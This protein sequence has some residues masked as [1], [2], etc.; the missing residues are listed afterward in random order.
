MRVHKCT[1]S[2]EALQKETK[3]FITGVGLYKAPEGVYKHVHS[4]NR[5]LVLASNTTSNK[6]CVLFISKYGT[7]LMESCELTSN[8]PTYYRIEDAEVILEIIE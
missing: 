8:V 2:K 6:K 3:T 1:T 4:D 5:Y 7:H